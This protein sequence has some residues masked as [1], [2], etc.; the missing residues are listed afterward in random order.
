MEEGTI[1]HVD[2]ELYNGESGDLI[3][4]TREAVAKEHEMH[5]EGRSYT[6]MVCVVGGGNLIPGFEAALADAKANSQ[7]PSPQS[8]PSI[9]LMLPPYWMTALLTG[10]FSP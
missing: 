8:M 10:C 7:A 6:P 2:Y 9:S 1:V 5:Q 4:T 3:E